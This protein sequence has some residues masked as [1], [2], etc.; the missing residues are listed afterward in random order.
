MP[1]CNC[2]NRSNIIAGTPWTTTKIGNVKIKKIL[3]K[4]QDKVR[5]KEKKKDTM[6]L[7]ISKAV[8]V[9]MAA[10]ALG[11][12]EEYQVEYIINAITNY[13]TLSRI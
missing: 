11:K 5:V 2:K 7:Q 10:K 9:A 12:I 1:P 4:A 8:N 3:K 13:C 6:W